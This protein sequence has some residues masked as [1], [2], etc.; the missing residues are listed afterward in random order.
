[1][2]DDA[3]ICRSKDDIRELMARYCFALDGYR[4]HDLAALFTPDGVWQARYGAATGPAA[5]EALLRRVAPDPATGAVQRHILTNVVIDLHE[6]SATARSYYV[7]IRQPAGDPAIQ[8]VGEYQD[9][10]A[11]T[12]EG[13]RFA[14]R[15][16]VQVM[17]LGQPP[18][19]AA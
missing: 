15:V 10:L 19:S 7:V 16:L 14:R 12:P 2:T 17:A 11:R 13:W 18:V 8:V 3:A 5:I 9:E 1:M 6:A 4:L